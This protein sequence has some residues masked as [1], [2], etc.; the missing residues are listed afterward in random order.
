MS[1]RVAV[2]SRDGIVV[3]Q[4][5]GKATHFQIYEVANGHY[6]Y[7]ETRE[8]DPSCRPG[9]DHFTMHNRTLDKLNDCN[10]VIVSQIGPGAAEILDLRGIKHFTMRECIDES[11]RRLI[12]SG[13]L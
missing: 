8:N 1:T 7:I 6:T 5:F 4:H 3:H 2:A 10:A 11:L 9:E 12:E 13:K